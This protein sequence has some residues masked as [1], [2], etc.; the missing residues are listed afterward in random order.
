MR[1]FAR[2]SESS[3]RKEKWDMRMDGGSM[4]RSYFGLS[5]LFWHT[6][7]S[8]ISDFWM[9]E[10][11]MVWEKNLFLYQNWSV[12]ICLHTRRVW[13]KMKI[14]THTGWSSLIASSQCTDTICIKKDGIFDPFSFS[15]FYV[16]LLF[17]TQSHPPRP[18]SSLP[19]TYFIPLSK[20]KFI[21]DN[22]AI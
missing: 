17:K 6:L 21:D 3:R 16:V 22:K 12:Q 15:C 4:I 7:D 2:A 19:P 9:T 18:H 20:M 8:H 10:E 11:G 1:N 13:E 14:F 5:N